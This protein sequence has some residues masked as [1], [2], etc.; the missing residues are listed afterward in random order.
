[1][2]DKPVTDSSDDTKKVENARSSTNSETTEAYKRSF[3]KAMMYEA[4]LI[5]APRCY[6]DYR[7]IIAL[8]AGA[9]VLWLIHDLLPPF[10]SSVEFH[11]KLW[12]S[13]V[14]WQPVIEEILFRG[15]LQGQLRKTCWGQRAW[16][17]IS[18]ANVV[19]SIVFVFMHMINNPPL[20]SISVIVPSLLFGY[21][22]DR[23]NSV[24]PSILLHSAFNA[25]VIE[26]LFI[27]GNMVQLPL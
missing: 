4:G 26:A 25:F 27:H 10:S 8:L 22:R 21:F 7:F 24:Y 13:L 17:N 1:M 20:F 18:A 6:Q 5:H 19:T 23:C 12:I 2:N 14:I 15:I 11:W 16:L 9:L 3:I